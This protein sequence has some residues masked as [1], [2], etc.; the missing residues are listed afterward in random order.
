[1]NVDGRDHLAVVEGEREARESA[2]DVSEE[3]VGRGGV[4]S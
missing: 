3:A 4:Y 1:M 2:T